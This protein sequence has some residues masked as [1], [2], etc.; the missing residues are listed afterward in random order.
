MGP[1][2]E[3]HFTPVF[4]LP[5]YMTPQDHNRV[6]HMYLFVPHS[7]AISILLMLSL[8]LKMS[9]ESSLIASFTL[10]IWYRF[11]HPQCPFVWETTLFAYHGHGR[12]RTLLI[13]VVLT[14]LL[15][16]WFISST[17]F[18]FNWR[19]NNSDNS[20]FNLILLASLICRNGIIL[21]S[22]HPLNLLP[23]CGSIMICFMIQVL[24]WEWVKPQD[25]TLDLINI[26]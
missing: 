4:K 17:S 7:H 14:T 12:R 9:S 18:F 19:M 6:R 8:W 16:W 20:L 10:R 23:L 24:M 3:V 5:P 25:S 1:E 15:V 13:F 2:Y 22:I 11:F 26:G 21:N